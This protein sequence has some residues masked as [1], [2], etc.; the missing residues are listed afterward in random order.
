[1]EEDKLEITDEVSVDGKQ[2]MWKIVGYRSLEPC[3]EVQLGNNASSRSF[4]RTE[5]LTL[6]SEAEKP[7]LE[8][9]LYPT[10]GIMGSS[11]ER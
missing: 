7:K 2:G 11:S 5:R 6:V 10:S 1:M 4:E 3:W 9:G 8:P